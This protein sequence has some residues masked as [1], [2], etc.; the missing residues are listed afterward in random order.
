MTEKLN[1]WSGSIGNF[2]RSFKVTEKE[3]EELV[4]AYKAF[5]ETGDGEWFNGL[6]DFGWDGDTL[7]FEYDKAK[8]IATVTVTLP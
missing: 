5:G 6:F 4:K 2:K 8:G 3:G 7:N 1:E